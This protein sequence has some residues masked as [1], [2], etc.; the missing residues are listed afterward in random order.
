MDDEVIMTYVLFVWVYCL[1]VCVSVSAYIFIFLGYI[2]GGLLEIIRSNNSMVNCW[3]NG[4]TVFER[5]CS[6]F[7]FP[8]TVRVPLSLYACQNLSL[9]GYLIVAILIPVHLYILL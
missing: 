3:K 7:I 1:C 2:P 9:S 5:K 6:I 4:N 8:S